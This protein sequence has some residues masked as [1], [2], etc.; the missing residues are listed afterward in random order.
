[1]EWVVPKIFNVKKNTFGTSYRKFC[2]KYKTP[3]SHWVVN[4]LMIPIGVDELFNIRVII[5][6]LEDSLNDDDTIDASGIPEAK[7][8]QQLFQK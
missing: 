2:M 5:S 4:S 3:T 6:E 8:K 1:M 7:Q